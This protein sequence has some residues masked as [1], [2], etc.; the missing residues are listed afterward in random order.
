MQTENKEKKNSD[1]KQVSETKVPKLEEFFPIDTFIQN[2]GLQ[3]ISRNIFKYLKLKDFSN[4]YLVS[5]GW[6]QFID[7]DKYLANVQLTEVMSLYSKRKYRQEFTP[8]HYVCKRGSLRIV[9]LFLD[10]KKKMAIDVNAQYEGWTPL[11][12]ATS[13]NN[14]LVIKQLLNH[15]LDVTFRSTIEQNVF[16]IACGFGTEDT[17]NFLIQ[18]ARKYNVDLNLRDTNGYT[19]FHIACFNGKLEN[20]KILLKNSK[21]I[22]R[23]IN[24]HSLTNRCE[25]G[26]DLAEQNG[27]TDVVNLIKDWRRKRRK[28]PIILS[29]LTMFLTISY[30]LANFFLDLSGE[31]F[32][33]LR[34][35]AIFLIFFSMILSSIANFIYIYFS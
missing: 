4:C 32:L 28:Q 30:F 29:F 20:V 24:V 21:F 33:I 5:K 15:G 13:F 2:P 18:N 25:F 1:F 12:Y 19:P 16:H 14:A 27:H 31:Q 26:Q 23:K 3:L 35:W 7:E 34:F 11:F 17:V 6:K 10:N 22:F 8:F 9:K